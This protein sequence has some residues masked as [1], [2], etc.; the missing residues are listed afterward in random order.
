MSLKAS[1]CLLCLLQ[2]LLSTR[3]GVSGRIPRM[4]RRHASLLEPPLSLSLCS[5]IIVVFLRPLREPFGLTIFTDGRESADT[6][7]FKL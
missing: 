2:N 7:Q 6:G 4:K 3:E 1:F 5:C